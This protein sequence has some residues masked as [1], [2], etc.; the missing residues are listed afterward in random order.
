MDSTRQ[1]NIRIWINDNQK[2]FGYALSLLLFLIGGWAFYRITHTIPTRGIADIYRFFVRENSILLATIT[3]SLFLLYLVPG[4]AGKSLRWL[5]V[6]VIFAVY[7][8]GE[9][10]IRRTGYFQL[11]GIQ[12][13]VDATEYYANTQRLLMGF[14]SQG[15]TNARPLFSA[16]FS[17]LLWITSLDMVEAITLLVFCVAVAYYLFGESLRS[18]FGPITAAM[19]TGLTFMFYRNYLGAITSESLGLILGMGGWIVLFWAASHKSLSRFCAGLALVTLALIAR[20]GPFVVLPAIV[21]AGFFL[22]KQRQHWLKYAATTIATIIAGFG[23]NSLILN[24]YSQGKSVAFTSY[25]YSLY[26]MAAGGKSWGY[27][28]LTHPDVFF[29]MAEPERT[30]TIINL[31]WELIKSNPWDLIRSMLSQYYFFVAKLNTSVFSYLFTQIDWY[32]TAILIVL[33]TLS[34][35]SIILLIKNHRSS[36][37]LIMLAVF[38]GVLLS[39]PL[40]PPQDELDMRPYAVVVP[41]LNILPAISLEWL[42]ARLMRLRKTTSLPLD[43]TLH[44]TK[45]LPG[46]P[47]P[48]LFSGLVLVALLFIPIFLH[49]YPVTKTS[50][51][52]TCP[53]GQSPFVWYHKPNNATNILTEVEWT[54]KNWMTIRQADRLK[55]D[56]LYKGILLFDE[57]NREVVFSQSVNY[58]D[59]RSAWVVG[60]AGIYKTGKGYYGGCGTYVDDPA[61][62]GFNYFRLDSAS[63]LGAK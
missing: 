48:G 36:T 20:A 55:H 27:I 51:S 62:W 9:W 25:I 8:Q 12:P 24:I 22:F 13:W 15:T 32:N 7:L 57:F 30:Q 14:A 54:G 34:I 21:V 53:A 11:Y 47:L 4:K 52:V 1:P 37:N 63:F 40:V 31:T 61:W 59:N 58:L 39:I 16:F 10:L 38:V 44:G 41:I 35:L 5:W 6:I 2:V 50:A 43:G 42:V 23:I 3:V 49:K 33:Y 56:L 45:S 60:D 17:I 28:K 18:F 46:S 19:T 29:G 26:G